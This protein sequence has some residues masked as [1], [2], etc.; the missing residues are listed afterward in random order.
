[1]RFHRVAAIGEAHIGG[2]IF[3]EIGHPAID[4]DVEHF[5]AQHLFGKPVAG[6]LAGE[7]EHAAVEFAEIDEIDLVA[8]LPQAEMAA[9]PASA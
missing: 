2:Q 9:R 3:A 4:A 1:M 8:F 7:I 6:F 5:A